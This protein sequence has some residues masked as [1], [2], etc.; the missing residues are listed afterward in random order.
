LGSNEDRISKLEAK[1]GK[2]EIE[3]AQLKTGAVKDKNLINELSMG[4]IQ[5]EGEIPNLT[6]SS[7]TFHQ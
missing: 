6:V 5:L 3:I 1:R 2:Q 4:V 7:K